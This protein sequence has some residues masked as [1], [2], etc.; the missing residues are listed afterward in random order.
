VIASFLQAKDGIGWSQQSGEVIARDA[1]V[2][3]LWL[4]PR[5]EI[6]SRS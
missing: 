1:I 2:P 5:D 3:S 4:R 6:H